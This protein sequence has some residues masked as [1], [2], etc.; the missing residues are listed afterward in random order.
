MKNRES[1]SPIIITKQEE[2]KKENSKEE[3][4]HKL[5]EKEGSFGHLKVTINPKTIMKRWHEY[6]TFGPIPS[7]RCYM[8]SGVYK[9]K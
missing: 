2:D 6:R 4:I 7:R 8:A 1:D 9:D 5:T 3:K